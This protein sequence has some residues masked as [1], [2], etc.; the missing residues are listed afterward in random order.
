[1]PLNG[2]VPAA[3][4]G[5]VQSSRDTLFTSGTL[6]RYSKQLN[7]LLERGKVQLYDS[8]VSAP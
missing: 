4:E 3:A 2:R 7:S 6:G 8:G 5:T 1:M